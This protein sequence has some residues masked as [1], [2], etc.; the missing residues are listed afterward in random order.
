SATCSPTRATLCQYVSFR[1]R[2]PK[3]EESLWPGRLMDE[4]TFSASEGLD[5]TWDGLSVAA[6]LD[7]SPSARVMSWSSSDGARYAPV[8]RDWATT[9]TSL[10]TPGV[11]DVE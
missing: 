9:E 7:I 8:S 5:R 4:L 6:G 10:R 3:E 2:L 1:T 11:G